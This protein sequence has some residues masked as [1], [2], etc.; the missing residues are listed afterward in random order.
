MREFL[1]GRRRFAIGAA[2]AAASAILVRPEPLS[3][4]V[5]SGQSPPAPGSL[6]EQAQAAL[7]KLSPQ[8][9]AE[10]E[11][12]ASACDYYARHAARFLADEPVES[13]AGKSAVAY[14]PLGTVLAIMPWNFPFW[15]V[16]RF[17][18]PAL[19][20]GNA[21]LLKHASNVPQCARALEQ[22]FLDAGL[23]EGD[24]F[25]DGDDGES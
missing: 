23:P 10:V 25:L 24:A 9:R 19:M 11:K 3:S 17:S 18:V 5:Q 1:L 6:E 8:A 2:A 4:E 21:C 13:D 16:F 22:I 20:A 15:Q 14:Q 12:C 7:G